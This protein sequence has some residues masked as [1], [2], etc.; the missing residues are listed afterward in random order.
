MALDFGSP[1][2]PDVIINVN[3]D[4]TA[5]FSAWAM[6]GGS[7]GGGGG[8]R[9][10]LGDTLTGGLPC[11]MEEAPEDLGGSPPPCMQVCE[12]PH[13]SSSIKRY[14]SDA[15]LAGVAACVLHCWRSVM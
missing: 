8:G 15:H 9:R 2:S 6:G 13:L 4:S 10:S 14:L 5:A 7:A 3:A 1:A 12:P 11:I